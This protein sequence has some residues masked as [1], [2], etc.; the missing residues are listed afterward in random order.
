MSIHTLSSLIDIYGCRC[1]LLLCYGQIEHHVCAVVKSTCLDLG[2]YFIWWW[3]IFSVKIIWSLVCVFVRVFLCVQ[4]SG[5]LTLDLSLIVRMCCLP[6][7][8]PTLSL[9][10]RNSV[11]M[12]SSLMM[13]TQIHNTYTINQYPFTHKCTHNRQQPSSIINHSSSAALLR[14]QLCLWIYHNMMILHQATAWH[15]S[16]A[17]L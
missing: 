15:P 1:K 14:H 9:N 13:Q 4:E 12:K 7:E 11:S 3:M 5:Y 10:V 17:E 16:P 6:E 2:V 8:S